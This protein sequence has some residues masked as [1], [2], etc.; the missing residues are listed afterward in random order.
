ME[1][2]KFDFFYI[3][4]VVIEHSSI[5]KP[6]LNLIN[7]IPTN[8]LIVP[9]ENIFHTDWNLPKDFKRE[10]LDYFLIYLEPYLKKIANFLSMEIIKLHNCWFQQYKKQ[11][12]HEWHVHPDAN[13]TNIYYLELPKKNMVTKFFNQNNNEYIEIEIKEGDLLTFPACVLHCSNPFYEDETK[14][15]ISF[16]TSFD[17]YKKK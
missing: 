17:K 10:Y 8:K 12:F 4:N 5:K 11:N 3:K 7:K 9:N 15:I 6:I 13:Y 16:N 14:T 2:I 1:I